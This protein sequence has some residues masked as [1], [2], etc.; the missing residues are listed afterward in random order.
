MQAHRAGISSSSNPPLS[1]RRAR[2]ATYES[3]RVSSTPAMLTPRNRPGNGACLCSSQNAGSRLSGRGRPMPRLLPPTQSSES[4]YGHPVGFARKD[5]ARSAWTK[6][7][8][9]A[10]AMAA[11]FPQVLRGV[12]SERRTPRAR[13]DRGA[14]RSVLILW[15]GPGR[16]ARRRAD[17]CRGFQGERAAS[18]GRPSRRRFLPRVCTGQAGV[19]RSRREAAPVCALR[20]GGSG[21]AE[22]MGGSQGMGRG[23]S[24]S[25][26]QLP[27]T[28]RQA[29]PG[30]CRTVPRLRA[31]LVRTAPSSTKASGAQSF[32][33]VGTK[34][35]PGAGRGL[36]AVLV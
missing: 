29:D 16:G 26:M 36:R 4:G 14:P 34:R 12:Y 15:G 10:E 17:R 31:M 27:N 2:P 25:P 22:G 8:T 24:A 1:S 23:A 30:P 33:P 20:P 19:P 11:G 9:H 18:P 13:P 7:P 32:L 3:S 21:R 5:A 28:R 35:L 6:M